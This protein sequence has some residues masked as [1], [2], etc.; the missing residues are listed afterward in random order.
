MQKKIS[1]EECTSVTHFWPNLW[2]WK[3]IGVENLTKVGDLGLIDMKLP[4]GYQKRSGE[5]QQK[6]TFDTAFCNKKSA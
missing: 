2:Q 3:I 1:T 5:L 6:E 4:G